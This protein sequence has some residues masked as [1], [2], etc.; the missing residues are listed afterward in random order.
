VVPDQ[1]TAFDRPG[2]LPLSVEQISLRNVG[3][4]TQVTS[5]RWK[6]RAQHLIVLA[7][8]IGL[9]ALFVIPFLWMLSASI[10][11]DA[12]LFAFPIEWVP[13]PPTLENY[14]YGMTFVPFDRYILNTL[15]VAGFSVAGTVIS[16]SMVAYSLARI[17]WPGRNILFGILLATMMIPFPVTMIPLF[18]MFSRLGWV[19]TFLPLTVPAFFGTAF[20]IFLLRQF[21]MTIPK[22]LTDAARVDGA[23]ELR[24]FLGVVIPLSKPALA[25]VALF[26]FIGS[27]SDFLGPLIYLGGASDKF[28]VSLG[29]SIFQGEYSTEFGALMAAS[30]VML[31]PIVVL[32]FFTQRTFIQGITLTGIKG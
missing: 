9:S 16:C 25:S 21:F 24:I 26:Q 3:E 1:P 17:N 14:R 27:W 7:L 2:G 29:L 12:Q 8:L 18:I 30:T 19:N 11:T 10:K 23:N 31:L 4:T 6:K 13:N 15:I 28:T 32:F 22:D 20:F 5:A